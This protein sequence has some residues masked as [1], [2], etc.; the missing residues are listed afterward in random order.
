MDDDL[1]RVWLAL[2]LDGQFDDDSED[3]DD[4]DDDGGGAEDSED[5]DLDGAE[6]RRPLPYQWRPW[7]MDDWPDE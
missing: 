3:S 5:G 1:M 7:T 4:S 2:Y 6:R